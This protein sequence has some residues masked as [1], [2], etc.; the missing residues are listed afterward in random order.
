M[1][2]FGD[3]QFFLTTIILTIPVI[4]YGLKGRT[5]R[6]YNMLVFIYMVYNMLLGADDSYPSKFLFFFLFEWIV[7]KGY[8]WLRCRNNSTVSYLIALIGSLLPLVFAKHILG[9][10]S[11][12]VFLGVS[13]VT[14]RWIQMVMEIRDGLIENV[15][16]FDYASFILFFPTLSSGPIDRFR[17]FTKDLHT[18]L[19]GQ[20]YRQLLIKGLHKTMLGLLYKFII[21]F[22]I[23]TYWLDRLPNSNTFLTTLNYMYAYSLYLFFDFAGYSA[24]AV[25]MSYVFGVRTPDN[26]N[27]PFLSTSIKDF[28]NRWHI[29]LSTWFR[30]YVYMRLIYF[31]TKK[32]IKLNKHILSYIGYFVL[33]GLMG[34]WHGSQAYYIIYGFYH[35]V[36]MTGFDAFT[37]LNKDLKLWKSGKWWRLLSIIITFHGVCFGFLIF[38]GR[39]QYLNGILISIIIPVALVLFLIQIFRGKITKIFP[40]HP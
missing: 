28:W 22:F 23:K 8:G 25:G 24:L 19:S 18:R 32:K 33:F 20:E 29:S 40:A 2:A 31:C 39:I 15:K 7:I 5:I 17:R 3:L 30:D 9:F 16:F 14:F 37:Y 10:L 36:L 34:L 38:S 1:T 6:W 21:A 35:A 27:H 13:Y 4:V 26:F 11:P 12:M